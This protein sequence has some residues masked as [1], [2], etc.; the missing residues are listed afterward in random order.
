MNDQDKA[1]AREALERKQLTI[2]QVE[3]IRAEVDRT[4]RSFRDVALSKGLPAEPKPEK[5]PSLLDLPGSPRG[6]LWQALF[7]LRKKSS[8]PPL[9]FG[10][11]A[12]SFVIFSG[13]LVWTVV[14]LQERS[15][16]DDDLVLETARSNKDADRKSAEARRGYTMGVLSEKE[17]Q[18]RENL[19]KARAAMTRV[20]SIL[21]SGT[22][23]PE[24]TLHLNDAFVGFNM[25]L[26]V[27]PED[28]VVLVERARTH[29]LR[30]NFD[31]AV[32]DLERGVSLRPELEPGLKSRINQLRLLVARKPQ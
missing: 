9:Y 3:Q 22:L 1:F 13:L 21:Q 10:L 2:E 26:S 8:I 28:A 12:G 6:L 7:D 18:A 27:F 15:Q 29:E 4:G 24:L 11:L 16:K 23:P 30:R 19:A 20:E 17:G 32:A 31:L 14:K 5:Q 25:Y